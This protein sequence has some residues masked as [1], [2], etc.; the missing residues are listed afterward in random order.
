MNR[1]VAYITVVAS[2]AMTAGCSQSLEPATG[3]TLPLGTVGY[4]QALKV[5]QEVLAEHFTIAS[6]DERSGKITARP[7]PITA[8][9]ERLVTR[10]AGAP[11]SPA[12]QVAMIKLYR[13]GQQVEARASVQIQR[14][15][16]EIHRSRSSVEENYDGVPNK[17][18]VDVD[19]AATPDQRDTW[20]VVKQDAALEWKILQAI[21][22]RLREP[23]SK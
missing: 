13:N 6:V 17:T 10:L 9:A 20:Q 19:S 11:G 5:S 15:Y 12:R 16:S 4:G 22:K 1:Y 18:P 23:V 21:E 14:Q 2:V 8:Q 3:T 7:K